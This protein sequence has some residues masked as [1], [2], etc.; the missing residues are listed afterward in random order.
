[1]GDWQED[2]FPSHLLAERLSRGGEAACGGL[3][4]SETLAGALGVEPQAWLSLQGL[5]LLGSLKE[6]CSWQ[7]AGFIDPDPAQGVGGQVCL[8]VLWWLGLGCWSHC[9]GRGQ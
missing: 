9:P 6:K 5:G 4:A 1:M 8:A 2:V 7:S 3:S